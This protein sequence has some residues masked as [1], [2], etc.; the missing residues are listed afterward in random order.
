MRAPTN[1]PTYNG[2][3]N[4]EHYLILSQGLRS[5]S[6]VSGAPAE[7]TTSVEK[8]AFYLSVDEADRD[9]I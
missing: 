4:S 2:S 3:M 9:F 8:K 5:D 7:Y 6:Q 1:P